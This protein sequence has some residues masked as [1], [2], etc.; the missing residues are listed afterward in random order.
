LDGFGAE[1][2]LSAT[3]FW[4]ASEGTGIV[5]SDQ[6]ERLDLGFPNRG[7]SLWL[8][9]DALRVGV[10][11]QGLFDATGSLLVS[12]PTARHF[13]GGDA[14]W[15]A[16]TEDLVVAS[17]GRQ[18][19][20]PDPR[21]VRTD[22]ERIAVLSCDSEDCGIFLLDEAIERIGDGDAAGDLAFW[23]EELWWGRPDLEQDGAEGSIRSESGSSLS[24]LPG[25]HLGRSI[26]GGYGA[27]SVNTDV[28]PRRLRIQSLQGSQVYA[29]DRVAGSASVALDG[30][31]STLI[32]GVQGWAEAGGAVLVVHP[33][34]LP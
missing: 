11:G 4:A 6:D 25:D 33:P 26:G 23:Q 28:R 21:R 5:A 31:A 12:L 29:L 3:G 17:D 20:L 1:V 14:L 9:Q 13:S 16:C 22:G 2:L 7:L 8:E 18:W 30:D 32:I 24:G 34:E 19:Q 10:A 15:V 27:G